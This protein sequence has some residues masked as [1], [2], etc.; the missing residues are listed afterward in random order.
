MYDCQVRTVTPPTLPLWTRFVRPHTVVKLS[1][2]VVSCRV[3]SCRLVLALHRFDS[4]LGPGSI[5]SA[6]LSHVRRSTV[7]VHYGVLGVRTRHVCCNGCIPPPPCASV[8]RRICQPP[9]ISVQGHHQRRHHALLIGIADPVP[10]CQS[11]VH[12]RT[13]GIQSTISSPGPGP[14][15][16]RGRGTVCIMFHK[17][18]QPLERYN[19]GF[20]L[21]SKPHCQLILA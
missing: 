16:G 9:T 8:L 13:G 2:I 14:G 4:D 1:P 21:I 3:V 10:L 6:H 5:R 11:S 17:V 15:R 19:I 20:V 7:L 12:L 18:P